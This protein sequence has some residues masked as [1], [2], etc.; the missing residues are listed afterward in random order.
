MTYH[1]L[2]E[3]IEQLET[4]NEL[5]RIKDQVSP[6]LE[7]SEI[8]DRVSKQDRGGKAFESHAD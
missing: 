6:I 5:I 7:I 4:Q 8:T 1:S 3:F 2:R